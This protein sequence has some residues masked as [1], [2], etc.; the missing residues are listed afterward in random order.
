MM[1]VSPAIPGKIR[2]FVAKQPPENGKAYRLEGLGELWFSLDSRLDDETIDGE[3]YTYTFLY[4]LNIDGIDYYC[5]SRELHE[6]VPD[7]P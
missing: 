7:T 2:S 6:Q 4:E 1:Q 5:F 3:A